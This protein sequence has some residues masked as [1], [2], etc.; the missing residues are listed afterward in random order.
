VMQ[1]YVRDTKHLRWATWP[2]W[3]PEDAW[4]DR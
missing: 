3:A 2:F 4:L 1:K